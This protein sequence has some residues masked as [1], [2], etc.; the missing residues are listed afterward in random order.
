MATPEIQRPD[1]DA[2]MRERGTAF[3]FSPRVMQ[4][5]D[6]SWRAQYPLAGWSVSADT[7]TA[8]RQALAARTRESKAGDDWQLDAVREHL[9]RGPIAGV[10][11]IDLATNERIMAAENPQAALNEVVAGQDRIRGLGRE[12]AERSAGLNARLT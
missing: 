12:I 1:L 6:G 8:A 2:I 4:E 9:D 11:E 5:P 10:Y 7:E 3:V